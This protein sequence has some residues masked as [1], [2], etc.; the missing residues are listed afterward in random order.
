[1][2]GSQCVQS[3]GR[4]YCVRSDI[5]SGIAL[6][7]PTDAAVDT[8]PDAGPCVPPICDPPVQ[9]AAGNTF[10]CVRTQHGALWCWGAVDVVGRGDDGA[11]C[12]TSGRCA[13]P[14]PVR[15]DNGDG[16]SSPAHDVTS[17]AAWR[18]TGCYGVAS[19]PIRCWSYETG[20]PLGADAAGFDFL[21]RE[22]QPSFMN[23][24]EVHLGTETGLAI[25]TSAT[26]WYAWGANTTAEYGAPGTQTIASTAMPITPPV[27]IDTTG[28]IVR[29]GGHHGCG[30]AGGV[31]SCWGANEMGQAGAPTTTTTVTPAMAVPGITGAIE[32]ALGDVHSCALLD[33][34]DVTCWG[35]HDALGVTP[36]PATCAGSMP[37]DACAPTTIHRATTARYAHLAT[38]ALGSNACAIDEMQ[39]LW[40]WG[41]NY[42]ATT[43]TPTIPTG[44]PTGV[45]A[46]VAT[47]SHTCAIVGTDVYCYGQNDW[48][49]LGR[50]TMGMP[51]E[52]P[53]PVVWR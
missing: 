38:S 50:D 30:I 24:T 10:T 4:A 23:A 7:A 37:T 8:S 34:G 21:A 43:H 5:D 36:D 22:V 35:T 9:I 51:D 20:E 40:C 47:V 44:M 1:V 53:H 33:S 15:A 52:T 45:T 49:Q 13:I 19:E 12:D 3:G 18:F 6:D 11:G 2:D 28:P 16:T 41:A 42:L 17:I 31:V 26:T 29:L 48:G 25:T 27:A 32:L 39:R 14:A 46:A